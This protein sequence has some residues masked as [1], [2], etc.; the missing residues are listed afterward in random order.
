[1]NFPEALKPILNSIKGALPCN[2][3]DS[4]NCRANTEKEGSKKM[5][6]GYCRE[7]GLDGGLALDGTVKGKREENEVERHYN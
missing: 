3:P 1:M 6:S 4:P 7:E 2:V 5:M